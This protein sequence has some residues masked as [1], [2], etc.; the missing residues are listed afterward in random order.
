MRVA[1]TR[2][3]K[4]AFHFSFADSLSHGRAHRHA[5]VLFPSQS[6]CPHVYVHVHMH[7]HV[8]YSGLFCAQVLV[9][10]TDS[11]AFVAWSPDDTQLL[12][13]GNDRLLKLWQVFLL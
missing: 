5:H 4:P 12:T 10:H 7:V 11:L 8:R 3:R 13:C 1:Q 9:G 2:L 6:L